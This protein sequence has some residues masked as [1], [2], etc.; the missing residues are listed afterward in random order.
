MWR[1]DFAISQMSLLR[2]RV[3][4]VA[5]ARSPELIAGGSPFA[6]FGVVPAELEL[7]I[8]LGMLA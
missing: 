8:L 5:F 7:G 4:K 6:V 1:I 3:I 2:A